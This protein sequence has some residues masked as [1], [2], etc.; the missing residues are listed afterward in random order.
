MRNGFAGT[1]LTSST[2]T[3]AKRSL[4]VGVFRGCADADE[5]AEFDHK[6]IGDLALRSDV[7]PYRRFGGIA[8]SRHI[9]ISGPTASTE[10]GD[11]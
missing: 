9:L 10:A 7:P 3:G 1:S 4:V 6:S 5:L 2:I 11:E 8:T